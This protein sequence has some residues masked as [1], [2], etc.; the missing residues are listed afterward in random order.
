MSA[1]NDFALVP[2]PPSAVEKAEPSAKRILSGMVADTLALASAT[3]KAEAELWYQNGVSCYVA[4]NYPE[5]VKWYRK[6]ADQGVAGAQFSLGVCYDFGDG[7]LQDHAE[8]VKWYRQAAAQ[9]IAG[10]QNNL[11][12]CYRDGHG[13]AQDQAEAIKW[14]RKAVVQGDAR[15]QYNL[16]R[17]Y[18]YGM[19]VAKNE[20]EGIMWLKKSLEN[21]SGL[22]GFA[23]GN[24]FSVA[25]LIPNYSEAVKYYRR[26]VQLGDTHSAGNLANVLERLKEADTTPE[27]Q[28]SA[29]Q[30][31]TKACC[32]MGR[33]CLE[34]LGVQQNLAESVKWYRKA[35]EQGDA[36]AQTHLGALYASGSVTIDDPVDDYQWVKIAEESDYPGAALTADMI[37][38]VFTSP[39]EFQEAE[40]RYLKLKT[41]QPKFAGHK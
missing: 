39:E 13:V 29:E 40:R 26:A 1:N 5:A 24:H 3:V 38:S 4:Q 20:A 30:G 34:G 15:A 28:K 7:V 12:N 23:L 31:E 2:K 27:I 36:D 17:C 9:G 11:G 33:R 21:G 10:A 41:G 16:G 37:K 6:A 14:Y 19:G 32:E 8:A 35:A 22:A 18:L 25:S